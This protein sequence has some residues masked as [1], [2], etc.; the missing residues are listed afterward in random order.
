MRNYWKSLENPLKIIEN[1]WKSIEI[2]SKSLFIIA[3]QSPKNENSWKIHFFKISLDFLNRNLI[4]SDT[5]FF[6]GIWDSR[7]GKTKSI[8]S[9]LKIIE[10]PMKTKKNN[11]NT[12][13]IVGIIKQ[14]KYIGIIGIIGIIT[15][16]FAGS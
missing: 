12:L 16:R 6:L 13:K 1:Q 11:E 15:A 7:A 9:L 14:W 10:N 3:W 5:G 2:Q 8:E 4:G